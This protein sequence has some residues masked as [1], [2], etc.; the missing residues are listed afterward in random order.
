MRARLKVTGGVI[1]LGEPIA[2]AQA[3]MEFNP[4]SIPLPIK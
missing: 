3:K 1:S 4:A 2:V